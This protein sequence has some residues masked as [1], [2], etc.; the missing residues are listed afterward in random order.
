MINNPKHTRK[1]EEEKFTILRFLHNE[2]DDE[3]LDLKLEQLQLIPIESTY[4]F[5][6]QPIT[7]LHV[8]SYMCY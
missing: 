3:Q 7:K 1:E 8:S 6:F 5:L 4:L 2:E